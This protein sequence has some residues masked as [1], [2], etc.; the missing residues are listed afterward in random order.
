MVT[1]RVIDEEL[2][3]LSFV[4]VTDLE[5]HTGSYTDDDGRFNIDLMSGS[6]DDLISFSHIGYEEIKIKASQI[7]KMKTP[8][9]LVPKKYGLKEVTIKPVNAK[10]ILMDAMA[11][12]KDNYP[13]DFTRNHVI[14]K[15]YW[16]VRDTASRYYFFDFNM[17]L[18][19]YLAKDSPRIYTTDI[20]HDIYN[21][22][23]MTGANAL[24]SPTRLVKQMYPEKVFDPRELIKDGFKLVS[25]SEVIDSEEYNVITFKHKSPIVAHSLVMEGTAYINKKDKGIRFVNLHLFS[26]HKGRIMLFV[27]VDTLNY[28]EKIAFKKVEGKYV[29]DYITNS[30]YG[31]GRIFGQNISLF[32]VRTL[33]V[34]ESKMNLKMN[35]IE[36]KTEIDDILYREIPKDIKDLKSEPDIR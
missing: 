26:I 3:P 5:T 27:K 10:T 24:S 7:V 30:L 9:Q 23:R 29:L 12:I 1:G 19:S 32:Q 22:N 15:D 8:I 21:Q 36:M 11:H 16:K 20:R 18:P 13:T 25:T 34:S 28:Q 2:H 6:S 31:R 4:T 14:Y 33:K 17:Y 35:E